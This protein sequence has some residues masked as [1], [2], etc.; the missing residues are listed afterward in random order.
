MTAEQRYFLQVVSDYV[1]GNASAVPPDDVQLLKLAEIA[2]AQSMGG[3]VY[4]QCKDFLPR[5]DEAYFAFERH[6]TASV[7]RYVTSG[8]TYAVLKSAFDDAGIEMLPFKGLELAKYHRVPQLRTMG[9]IDLLIRPDDRKK[10]HKLLLSLGCEC[11][12]TGDAV[13][14]YKRDVVKIEVHEHM[15]YEK[16]GS[17]FDYQTYFDG[18]WDTAKDGSL[19]PNVQFLFLAAHTAKHMLNCGSGF[20]PLLDMMFMAKS[21]ELDRQY[22]CAEL[23]K[24]GLLK[25]VKTAFA[26]CKRLF[27]VEPPFECGDI[28]ESFCEE[29]TEKLFSDGIFGFDNRSNRGAYMAKD[30][31]RKEKLG[32][33]AALVVMLCKLF[34]KENTMSNKK[35]YSFL[36]R[37]KLLRPIAW[38]YRIFY[39][40]A[41]KFSD[42]MKLLFYP[43]TKRK[44]IE[45][46]QKFMQNWG[47]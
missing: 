21:G 16:L 33:F 1:C 23:E 36:F 25:F 44:E 29:A 39:C 15:I 32:F 35:A 18:A 14:K 24:I 6:F 43:F 28:S 10:A 31:K 7:F 3:I 30:M 42:S 40:I 38:I 19:D 4:A 8:E 47:L 46:R 5:D 2:A 20:R 27:G 26:L 45:K 17:D 11:L 9:D 34:P 41:T 37:H 13:W 12:E 22:I